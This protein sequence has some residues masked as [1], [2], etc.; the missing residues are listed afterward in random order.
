MATKSSSLSSL[1][2]GPA[3]GAGFGSAAWKKACRPPLAARNHHLLVRLGLAVLR[4]RVADECG[5]CD[6]FQAFL[7]YCRLVAL[8]LS[9]EMAE[10]GES[11]GRAVKGETEHRLARTQRVSALKQVRAVSFT[12]LHEYV[13]LRLS[14]GPCC[15]CGLFSQTLRLGP[16]TLLLL[17]HLPLLLC[18]LLA[19]HTLALYLFL[20]SGLVQSPR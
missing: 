6:L 17:Q 1:G 18:I 20:Y 5:E 14:H 19:L 2:G 15:R 9:T 8:A 13:C 11:L 12:H 16:T 7:G 3:P 10:D 4:E